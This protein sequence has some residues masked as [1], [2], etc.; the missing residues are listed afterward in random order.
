[1]SVNLW[2]IFIFALLNI[3]FINKKMFDIFLHTHAC[4]HKNTQTLT[5]VFVW[6]CSW[7]YLAAFT[8]AAVYWSAKL[9]AYGIFVLKRVIFHVMT[10]FNTFNWVWRSPA[11]TCT[12]AHFPRV[13]T[14]ASFASSFCR[15]LY[16]FSCAKAYQSLCGSCLKR[17]F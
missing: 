1:M 16:R 7:I 11:S 10:Y 6:N 4:T 14:F 12:L 5:R 2:L 8:S 13:F 15:C 9:F 3:L 17:D